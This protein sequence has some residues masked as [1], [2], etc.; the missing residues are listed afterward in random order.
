MKKGYAVQ[1]VCWTKAHF[2]FVSP[3]QIEKKT[4][5]MVYAA[6]CL[7]MDLIEGHVLTFFDQIVQNDKKWKTSKTATVLPDTPSR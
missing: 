4:Q 3:Q 1:I 6:M 7:Y 2:L 5:C